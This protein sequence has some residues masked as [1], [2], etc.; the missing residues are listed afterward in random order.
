[1]DFMLGLLDISSGGIYNYLL[2]SQSYC[3]H[4]A[5]ILH[6]L[7]SCLRASPAT[8]IRSYCIHYV[9]LQLKTVFMLAHTKL[10]DFS[11]VTHGYCLLSLR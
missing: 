10:A 3:N 1:M 9:E 4:T 5:L 8:N 6:R 7:T 11:A 2:Q